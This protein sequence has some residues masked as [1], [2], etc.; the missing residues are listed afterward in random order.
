MDETLSRQEQWKEHFRL[1]TESGLTVKEYC[2]KY[3]LNES[4]YWHY[5]KKISMMMNLQAESLY[6]GCTVIRMSGITITA[7]QSVPDA[8]ICRIIRAVRTGDTLA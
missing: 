4:T 7:E 1:R 3:G 6:D 5:H 8:I 2:A